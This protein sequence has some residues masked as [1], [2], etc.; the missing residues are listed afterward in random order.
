MVDELL[1]S[2]KDRGY[3]IEAHEKEGF[4]ARSKLGFETRTL[5]RNRFRVSHAQNKPASRVKKSIHSILQ[6]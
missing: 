6:P 2:L 5:S 3:E 1:K 4:R